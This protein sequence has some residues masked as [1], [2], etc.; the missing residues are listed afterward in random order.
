MFSAKTVEFA[1][2]TFQDFVKGTVEKHT[3][4]PRLGADL[5]KLMAFMRYS[6]VGMI[7]TNEY[8]ALGHAE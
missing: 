5:D 3:L 7:I 6:Q 2:S 1:S 8:C 4:G